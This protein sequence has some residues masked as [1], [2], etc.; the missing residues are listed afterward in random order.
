[1]PYFP[2]KY[3][4]KLLTNF[5]SQHFV[6]T[7]Q[8]LYLR[9]NIFYNQSLQY[10]AVLDWMKALIAKLYLAAEQFFFSAMRK[11]MCVNKVLWTKIHVQIPFYPC[12]RMDN[13]LQL[14]NLMLRVTTV[15][16]GLRRAERDE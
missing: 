1:M 9:Q 5:R 2:D 15:L 14:H 7:F 8:L 16:K 6:N 4:F 10:T 11:L 13:C 12:N 3:N